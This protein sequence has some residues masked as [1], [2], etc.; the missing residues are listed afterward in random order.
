M[1]SCCYN[2][3]G[4]MTAELEKSLEEASNGTGAKLKYGQENEIGGPGMTKKQQSKYIRDLQKRAKTDKFEG[5]L[6]ARFKPK[7][8]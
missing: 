5:T 4:N 1:E 6:F 3:D 7:K 8:D 2:F